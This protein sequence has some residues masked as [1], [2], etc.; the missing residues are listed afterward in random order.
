MA[1][2]ITLFDAAT[3]GDAATFES[4]IRAA[5]GIHTVLVNGEVVWREGRATG[6]R[7][8]RVLRPQ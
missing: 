4:P 8:G 3:V 2:D 7:P 5:H 1:A 6:A